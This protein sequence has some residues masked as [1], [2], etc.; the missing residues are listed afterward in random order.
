[1]KS[2]SN[3]IL[4]LIITCAGIVLSCKTGQDASNQSSVQITAQDS[5][6]VVTLGLR[7]SLKITLANPGDGGYTFDTL[8]YNSA[9]LSLASHV[10]TPPTTN[11]MGNF[12]TDTWVFSALKTGSTGLKVTATRGTDKNSTV[13][14]FN[15]TIAVN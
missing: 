8:Q 1:M 5:G 3:L 6:K 9:L 14:M 2:E 15:G 7:Q 13:T 10:H 4:I 11:A 12:G